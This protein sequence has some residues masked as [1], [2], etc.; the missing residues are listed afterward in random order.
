MLVYDKE[1]I[2][3]IVLKHIRNQMIRHYR[4]MI[5]IDGGRCVLYGLVIFL[6]KE[7]GDTGTGMAYR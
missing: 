6:T 4:M 1:R 3:H 5:F 2:Y 7:C